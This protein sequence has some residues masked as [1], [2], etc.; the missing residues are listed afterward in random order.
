MEFAMTT[1][2]YVAAS[3]I[4]IPAV[5]RD[6]AQRAVKTAQERADAMKASAEKATAT[7]E[8]A[9]TGSAATVADI[10]RAV[11][12]AIHADVKATLSSFEKMTAAG[13]LAEAAQIHVEFLGERGRVGL[14]RMKGASDYLAKALQTGAKSAQDAISKFAPETAKAA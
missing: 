8:S 9:Y 10:A 6:L 12:D 2:T 5:A 14:D 13:S 11:Q 1:E 3:K 7:I 4:E